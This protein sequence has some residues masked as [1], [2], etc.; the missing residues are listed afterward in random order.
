MNNSN[1]RDQVGEESDDDEKS[2][3]IKAKP[4]SIDDILADSDEENDAILG[5]NE[6]NDEKRTQKIKKTKK[7]HQSYIAEGE[8]NDIVDFLDPSAAQNVTSTMPKPKSSELDDQH[9]KSRNGGFKIAKDGRLII[10]D[11][12]DS[13]E[14]QHKKK[15]HFMESDGSDDEDTA[16][17]TFRDLVHSSSARKRKHGGSVASSKRSALSS[18]SIESRPMKYKAGG[19]GIH[20]PLNGSSS[21]NRFPDYGAEYRAKKG[22]GDVKRKDKPDPYAYIPLKKESLNK[23]KKAKFEGQFKGIVKAAQKGSTAGKKSGKIT[24][25]MKHLKM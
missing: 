6:D 2:F 1:I 9:S 14:E 15:L 5:D 16:K 21:G 18:M 25:K 23:R 17:N 8:G 11:D 24:K 22:K 7:K 20:R 13:E 4:K 3:R 10:E 19:I 12:S